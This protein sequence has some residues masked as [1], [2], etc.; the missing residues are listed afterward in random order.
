MKKKLCIILNKKDLIWAR[1]IIN[2][3][4]NNKD[5]IVVAP[6]FDGALAIKDF[7]PNYY[8]CE[9]LAWRINKLSLHEQANKILLKIFNIYES[10]IEDILPKESELRKYPIFKMHYLSFS[11]Y[12]IEMLNS[13]TYAN[14]ILKEFKPTQIYIGDHNKIYSKELSN[15]SHVNYNVNSLSF[16]IKLL[17]K[18]N[19]TNIKQNNKAIITITIVI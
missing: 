5:F 7:Y 1:K 4:I 10:K 11:Y 18:K 12:L 3:N 8:N 9:N 19:K 6:T 17:C 14:S 15:F 13:N 2:Q 16:S